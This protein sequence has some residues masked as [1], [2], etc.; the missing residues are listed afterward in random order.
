MH[1]LVYHISDPVYF[2]DLIMGILRLIQSQE[3]G[4]G[5]PSASPAKLLIYPN[6]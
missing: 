3:Q 4:C 1:I 2:K 6:K 5:T